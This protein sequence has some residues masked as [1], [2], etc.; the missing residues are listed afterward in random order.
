MVAAAAGGDPFLPRTGPGV[1]QE[2]DKCGRTLGEG[3]VHRPA[4]MVAADTGEEDEWDE[5]G[6]GRVEGG[7]VNWG[8]V[9]IVIDSVEEV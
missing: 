1:E 6:A 2:L 7:D 3:A 8:M 9:G 5:R 4:G